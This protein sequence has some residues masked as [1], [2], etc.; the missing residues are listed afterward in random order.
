LQYSTLYYEGC[1]TG[2]LDDRFQGVGDRR[3][4]GDRM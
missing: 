4:P 2:I 1:S 3:R